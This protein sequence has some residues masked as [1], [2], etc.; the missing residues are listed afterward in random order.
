VPITFHS[1]EAVVLVAATGAY[2][3][4]SSRPNSKRA[5]APM[6]VVGSGLI[7]L[8]YQDWMPGPKPSACSTPSVEPDAGAI[9]IMSPVPSRRTHVLPK[10]GET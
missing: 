7:Q 10:S 8:L 4:T 1:G 6:P 9:A 3:Q 5:G 2:C